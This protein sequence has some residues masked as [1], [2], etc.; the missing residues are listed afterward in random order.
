MWNRKK[1]SGKIRSWLTLAQK[2]RQETTNNLVTVKTFGATIISPRKL[3]VVADTENYNANHTSW[4]GERESK[5]SLR[6]IFKSKP[7]SDCLSL[8]GWTTCHNNIISACATG[9]NIANKIV[10]A[11]SHNFYLN[12]YHKCSYLSHISKQIFTGNFNLNSSL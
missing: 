9:N 8:G 7:F 2:G 3:Q 10:L 12:Y 4:K 11:I 5:Q 6:E 1:D